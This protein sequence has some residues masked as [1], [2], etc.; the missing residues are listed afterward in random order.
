[1]KIEI[2]D[3]L[4]FDRTYRGVTEGESHPP[5]FIPE[6]VALYNAGKLPV[7]QITRRYRPDQWDELAADMHAGRTL[8]PVIVWA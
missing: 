1:M 7:D 5:T 4:A 3:V 6:L 2:D 8:K